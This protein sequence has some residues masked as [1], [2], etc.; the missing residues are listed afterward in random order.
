MAPVSW[1]ERV[2][3]TTQKQIVKVPVGTLIAERPP[4]RSGQAAL[5]HPAPTLGKDAET[6]QRIRMTDRS[7]RKPPRNIPLHAA[8]R[9]M[10]ALT[11]TAQHRSPQVSHRPA[12][13]AQ[14]RSVHGHP[15]IAEMTQQDRAQVR[16]LFR[17]RR[18]QTL[19]QFVFQRP[20]F[21]L[22][23]L[24]H[25]LSQ[26]R[27]M[28]LPGLPATM[29][30]AQEVERFRFPAATLSPILLRIA[31]KLDDARFVGVQFQPELRESLAQLRQEPLRFMSMLESGNEVIGKTDEN[32]FSVRLLLS[33]LLDPEVEYIVQVDVRQQRTNAAALNGS[34]LTLYSLALFQH[35]GLEPFLDQAH[36]APVSYTMLDKL[37]QPSVVES[38]VKPPAVGIA[39]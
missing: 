26:H 5:P 31:A 8:P 11:A 10:V 39:H 4:D 32:H 16:S 2:R 33:P 35:A 3:T 6:H 19:P 29:R 13:R 34:H 21:R 23:P 25:R 28:P 15:V 24:P 18:M 1:N 17:D 20:Q 36:H 14:R 37:H 9:Q 27:E 30:E 7:R 12:E 22:P 38:V